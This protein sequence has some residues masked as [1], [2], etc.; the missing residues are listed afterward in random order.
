MLSKSTKRPPLKP[1]A[2]QQF[3]APDGIRCEAAIPLGA[4][5][6]QNAVK[7]RDLAHRI[8]RL[9]HEWA[10]ITQDLGLRVEVVPASLSLP[11]EPA[12]DSGRDEP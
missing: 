11:D 7:Q 8:S 10:R 1:I 12:Q 6:A 4:H 9:Q 5:M 3:T 2:R